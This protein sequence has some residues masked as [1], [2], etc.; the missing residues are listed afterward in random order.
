[1]KL[2]MRGEPENI[3]EL[4]KAWRGGDSAAGDELIPLVYQELRRIAARSRRRLNAGDTLQTTALIHEA[5]LRLVRIDDVDWRDRVH[6]FAVSAQLMR[7]MLIDQARSHK[8]AKRNRLKEADRAG[9]GCDRIQA[10]AASPE[11]LLAV[12]QALT[13]LAELDARRARI[14][15][16]R[17]FAGLSIEEMA[18][19]LGVSAVTVMRDWKVAKAWLTRELSSTPPVP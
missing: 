6:F 8:A 16:L 7:R 14:V 5:Y 1:M 17:V 19:V 4:L 9:D 11:D 2:Q 3:T 12:D 15:E 10:R 18:D 13:K